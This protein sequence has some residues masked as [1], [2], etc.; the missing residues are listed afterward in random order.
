MNREELLLEKNDSNKKKTYK[1]MT[2]IDHYNEVSHNKIN[3]ANS[4]QKD[5]NYLGEENE[6]LNRLKL[7]VDKQ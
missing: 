2:I 4:D 7:L 6:E 3:R 1:S 5:K